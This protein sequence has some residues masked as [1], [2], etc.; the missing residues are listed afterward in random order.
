MNVNASKRKR[1]S[2]LYGTIRSVGEKIQQLVNQAGFFKQHRLK[3]IVYPNEGVLFWLYNTTTTPEERFREPIT[4]NDEVDIYC[5]AKIFL[6]SMVEY[7]KMYIS[8][9]NS[10]IG[11]KMGF[12]LFYLQLLL[13]FLC[14]VH[15]VE[16]E[17]FTNNPV[18][19]A[20][21]G[22]IYGNLDVN[23]RGQ[24]RNNI[25]GKTL[26]EKLYLSEGKM[27]KLMRGDFLKDWAD[28]LRNI[29]GKVSSSVENLSN[30]WKQQPP[31]SVTYRRFI[32]S[33]Q[34]TFPVDFTQQKMKYHSHGRTV[35]KP[36]NR[37][38]TPMNIN[39][40]KRRTIKQIDRYNANNANNA[41]Q[42]GGRRKMVK[43]KTRR[44]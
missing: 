38:Q 19:A 23:M 8:Y 43:H 33:L 12:F 31:Y 1:I 32:H 11:F 44:M 30:P 21:E 35:K 28:R 5:S 16:L 24:K 13:A 18:R 22:A 9:V 25:K 41:N 34:Q 29:D 17:N 39:K 27:R 40:S 36:T 2:D 14:N 26:A 3:C 10:P 7:P 20:E 4:M 42:A 37:Q 6:P 15:E